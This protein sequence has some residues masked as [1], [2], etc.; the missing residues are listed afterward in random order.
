LK[1]TVFCT[2]FILYPN[3]CSVN[4]QK[5]E[6]GKQR[7]KITA[8]QKQKWPEEFSS[9]CHFIFTALTGSKGGKATGNRQ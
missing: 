2:T 1:D 3:I 5:F 6:T 9:S 7:G 8:A 4:S